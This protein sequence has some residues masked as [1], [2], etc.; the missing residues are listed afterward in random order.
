MDYARDFTGD[1]LIE[2]GDFKLAAGPRAA[3]EQA[4]LVNRRAENEAVAGDGNLRGWF[5]NSELGS[6]LW[7]LVGRNVNDQLLRTAE[8]YARNS[9]RFLKTAGL[10][11]NVEA[12]A[13][14]SSGIVTL[15]V[16][17]QL[18]EGVEEITL[19]DITNAA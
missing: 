19:N 12:E 14:A 16:R 8:E 13:T 9:L 2:N 6:L 10:V 15:V 11:Q 17:L 3:A 1:L 5:G 18:A 7:T 4:L